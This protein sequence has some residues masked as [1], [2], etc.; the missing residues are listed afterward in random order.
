MA[1]GSAPLRYTSLVL[2]A[3]RG[4]EDTALRAIES[5][6]KDATA[7]GEGRAIGLAHYATAVLYNGL[8]RYQDALAAARRACAYEDLGFFGWALGELVEAG[9]TKRRPRCGL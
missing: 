5:A 2:L 4:E 3:W 8:G 6:L 7:R 1:T 9:D